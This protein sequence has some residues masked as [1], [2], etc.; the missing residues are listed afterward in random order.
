M[1]DIEEQSESIDAAL[2]RE[3]DLRKHRRFLCVDRGVLRLSVRPEFRGRRAMLVDV[4]SG[5]IGFLV[6]EPLEADT[7][8]V[9]DFKGSSGTEPSN[10]I[11]RVR[12]SRPHTL[13][14]D[15]PWAP[16]PSPFSR[17]LRGFFGKKTA[18]TPKAWLVGCQFDRPLSDAEIAQFLDQLQ[19]TVT[20]L[21]A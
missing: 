21:E 10:R 5:G 3:A 6:E 7:M 18:T 15:A 2:Q 1:P 4:S 19:P 16:P 12:H 13:P 14:S 20:G 11:A 17:L 8:L 9:F